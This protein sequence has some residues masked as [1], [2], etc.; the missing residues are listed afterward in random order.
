MISKSSFLLMCAIL[1][2]VVH[3]SESQ[4][5]NSFKR[6]HIASRNVNCDAVMNRHPF[7][8]PGC[9]RLNTFIHSTAATV[10]SICRGVIRSTKITSRVLFTLTNCIY[11][12]SSGGRCAYNNSGSRNRICVTCEQGSPVHFVKVGQC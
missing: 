5:W 10:Q 4:N 11:R 3:L 2:C 9:K 1:L 6:K 7:R 8:I 12:A